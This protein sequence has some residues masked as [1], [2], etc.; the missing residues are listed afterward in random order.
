MSGGRKPTLALRL[1]VDSA[2]NQVIDG[3]GQSAL[4][5]GRGTS[6]RI[7]AVNQAVSIWCRVGGRATPEGGEREG[8]HGARGG[9]HEEALAVLF[10]LDLG[11]RVQVGADA[12]ARGGEAVLR[13]PSSF[14][15]TTARRL[16]ATW[17]RIVSSS[18]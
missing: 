10:D 16:P 7:S 14:F 17:P 5:R 3:A 2:P 4:G 1:I 15:R 9:V 11:E 12:G 13:S 6:L 18:L 8:G